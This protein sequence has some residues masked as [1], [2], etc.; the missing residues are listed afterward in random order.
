[1]NST[2][3][4]EGTQI[5]LLLGSLLTYEKKRLYS[6]WAGMNINEGIGFSYEVTSLTIPTVSYP[7]TQNKWTFR[8]L[9]L[10]I[11]VKLFF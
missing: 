9:L 11:F 8:P 6:H 5:Y 3:L 7:K 1:M 4:Y 2:Y 10:M